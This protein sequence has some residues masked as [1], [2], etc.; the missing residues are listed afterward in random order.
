MKRAFCTF[1]VILLL[2]S[3]CSSSADSSS[4][5]AL[6]IWGGEYIFNEFASPNIN[7]DYDVVI[8]KNENRYI[9]T[10][11]IDGFQTMTRV[12]ANVEGDGQSIRLLFD[13][14]LPDNMGATY[15]VNETLLSFTREDSGISTTW[16]A[17][18]PVVL[19]NQQDGKMYF[20]KVDKPASTEK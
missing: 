6:A 18:V 9:A 2:L 8:N 5:D 13:Q 12:Q 7:M 14:Y 3:G 17:I 19:E 20:E 1:A 16:G 15:E 4:E 10:I 11:Y